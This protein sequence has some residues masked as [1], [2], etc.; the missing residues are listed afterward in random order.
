M[1][2]QA[3]A[4]IPSHPIEFKYGRAPERLWPTPTRGPHMNKTR[5]GFIGLGMMGHGMAKNLVIKGFPTVI[6]GHRNRAPVEDLIAQGAAEAGNPAD[7]ALRSEIVF[8]CVTGS[9]QVEQ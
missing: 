6:L 1:A 4:T 7:L 2:E 8:L 5:V 9:P 3:A